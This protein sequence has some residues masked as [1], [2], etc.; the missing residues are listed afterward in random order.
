MTPRS[1]FRLGTLPITL[2]AGAHCAAGI[3]D[4]VRPTF[5]VPGSLARLAMES[6]H[7]A[8]T[9]R[10][11]LWS[12]WLGFMIG[13]GLGVAAFSLLLYLVAT[14]RFE[15]FREPGFAWLTLF[16]TGVLFVVSARYW[17]FA[18]TISIGTSWICFAA[19]LGWQR[20]ARGR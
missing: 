9:D 6:S 11:T 15:L 16:A 4:A 10:T 20:V 14:H 18:P 3:V 7:M 12:A 1:L 17:F 19:S 5:F 8:L 2:A 13:F